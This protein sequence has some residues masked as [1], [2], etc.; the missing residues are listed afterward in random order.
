MMIQRAIFCLLGVLSCA[1]TVFAD[2]SVTVSLSS[3]QAGKT[4]APG[5]IVDWTITATVSSGDNLG[6]ALISL[7]LVQGTANPAMFDLEPAQVVPTEMTGFSR[8]AGIS[9]IDAMGSGS[10][11]GGMLR[12]TLGQ[13][14]LTQIGGAQNTMGVAS[15]IMGQDVDVDTGIGQSPGGQIIASGT[16]VMPVAEGVYTFTIQSPLANVLEI[17]N[18]APAASTV[19]TGTVTV[20]DASITVT[21]A[22]TC[23]VDF[24][25]DGIVDVLDF[26][27]YVVLFN[28]SD[29]AADL[30][31]NG[32]VDVLDFF[33]FVN[34][35][36]AGCP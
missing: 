22:A 5:E 15:L 12:G 25:N 1:S 30:D 34:L 9:N 19:S 21:V 18:A 24:N 6:L 7:D 35:F 27:A 36:N 20:G 10:G 32:T 11:Y 17:V 29:P 26:F 14:N 8:P 23:P 4:V 16:F 31:G 33:L 2:G 28:S 13:Q 3:L